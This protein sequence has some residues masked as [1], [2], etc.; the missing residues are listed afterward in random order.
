M[1]IQPTLAHNSRTCFGKEGNNNCFEILGFD[2]MLDAKLKPWLIEVR[3]LMIS[4]RV[5]QP[6]SV[7]SD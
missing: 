4:A 3:Y 2:V 7:A 6:S 5:E 1:G